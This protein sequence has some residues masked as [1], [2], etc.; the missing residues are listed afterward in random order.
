M[1]ALQL[2]ISMEETP[3]KTISILPPTLIK[4]TLFPP[5]PTKKTFLVATTTRRRD[6]EL[7]EAA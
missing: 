4:K 1:S 5:I 3:R 6:Q 2:A 7:L